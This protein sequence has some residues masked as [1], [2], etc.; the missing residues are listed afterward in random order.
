MNNK[1]NPDLSPIAFSKLSKRKAKPSI[2]L[3]MEQELQTANSIAANNL[4]GKDEV[5]KV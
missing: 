5:R 3:E 1:F 2:A 4:I